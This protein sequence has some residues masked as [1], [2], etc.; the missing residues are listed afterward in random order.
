MT[1]LNRID[2]SLYKMNRTTIAGNKSIASFMKGNLV[3]VEL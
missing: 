3:Q 2:E 1:S